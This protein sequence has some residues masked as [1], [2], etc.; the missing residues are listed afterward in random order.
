MPGEFIVTAIRR[1]EGVII[2]EPKTVLKAKDVLMGV[3]KVAS[4]AK[5]KE[6]FSL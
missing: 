3:V 6:K 5:I 4:L 1:L 2:P